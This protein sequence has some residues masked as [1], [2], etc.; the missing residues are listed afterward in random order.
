MVLAIV[1]LSR[2]KAGLIEKAH[3]QQKD[4]CPIPPEA[5]SQKLYQEV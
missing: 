3:K 2:S 4:I 5:F 1:D